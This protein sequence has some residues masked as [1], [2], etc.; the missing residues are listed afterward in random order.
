MN[1]KLSTEE[2][3]LQQRIGELALAEKTRKLLREVFCFDVKFLD[4]RIYFNR[5]ARSVISYRENIPLERRPHSIPDP[6]L[7]VASR[8]LSEFYN[9]PPLDQNFNSWV[10]YGIGEDIFGEYLRIKQEKSHLL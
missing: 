3:L 5:C 8:F 2:R 10:L 9:I 6:V 1:E 7:E 4:E